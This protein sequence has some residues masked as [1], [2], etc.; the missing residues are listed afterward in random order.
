MQFEILNTIQYLVVLSLT[1][2][3]MFYVKD[4]YFKFKYRYYILLVLIS[5]G[6]THKQFYT[7]TE[8][9]DVKKTQSVMQRQTYSISN[10]KTLDN[11]IKL[12]ENINSSVKVKTTKELLKEQTELSQKLIESIESKYKGDK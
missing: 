9:R 12:K 5:T 1:T 8:V 10:D 11:Y 2:C 4:K 6:F 3:I 7:L